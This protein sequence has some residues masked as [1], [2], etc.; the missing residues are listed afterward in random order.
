MYFDDVDVSVA[1]RLPGDADGN[2]VVDDL[3]LTALASHWQQY[4][5]LADGDFN[6]DG[7][8]SQ[9]DLTVLATAW[10]SGAGGLELSAVPDPATL[11]LLMPCAL[12]LICNR[13]NCRLLSR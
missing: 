8:I 11:S 5:G 2:G 13:R 10:P 1:T 6:G 3:D 12:A 7:F 9:L 4:G